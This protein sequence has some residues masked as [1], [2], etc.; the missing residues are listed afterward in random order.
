MVGDPAVWREQSSAAAIDDLILQE[1]VSDRARP[2]AKIYVCGG[3]G[4]PARATQI[5]GS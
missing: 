1:D 2:A 5:V 3:A 4:V